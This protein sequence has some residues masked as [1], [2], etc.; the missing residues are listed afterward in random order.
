MWNIPKFI[1]ATSLG[2]DKW[3]FNKKDEIIAS[4]LI[5]NFTGISVREKGSINLIQNHL[6]I[7]P[8]F[9]LD[10]TLLINKKYYLNLIKN[11]KTDISKNFIFVYLLRN[12][13][14]IENLIQKA[15]KKFNYKI[16]NVNIDT[17][18]QIENFI[19]GIY[20]CKAVITDSYHGS[21]FSIIFN[22]PFISF[23]PKFNG[24]ERFN[25]LKE[26]FGLKKRIF[27]YNYSN[28][29][30]NLLK[31]SIKLN[32]NLLYSLKEQSINYLKKNLNI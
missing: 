23:S 5:K 20:H 18:N 1:Y 3:E 26:V 10:P 6:G 19:Y 28:P 16:F 30:I 24:V 9:V 15:S 17:I 27:E 4:Y 2:V 32:K 7:K 22:K 8:I 12:S 11:F 13:T 14:N 21:L 29:D 31:E 25:T